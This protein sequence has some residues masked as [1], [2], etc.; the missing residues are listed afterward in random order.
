MK[1]RNLITISLIALFLTSCLGDKK[2]INIEEANDTTSFINKDFKGNVIDYDKNQSACEGISKA[3]I[4]SLYGVSEDLI[5]V[6]DNVKSDRRDPNSNPSL[7]VLS[8]NWRIRF[9]WLRGSISLTPEV[10]KDEYMGEIAEA[11]G[12]GENWQEAWALQKSISESSEWVS[13]LGKAAVWK[14]RNKHLKNKI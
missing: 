14:G 4:A 9:M 2:G 5:R 11:A 7:F 12:N 8:R 1:N 13:G 6:I 10:G 3:D